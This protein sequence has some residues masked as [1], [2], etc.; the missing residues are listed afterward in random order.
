M[1]KILILFAVALFVLACKTEPKDYV[2][3][4]GKITNVNEFKKITIQN[5]EGYSKEITVNDDG[6]FKDT[7]KVVEGPYNFNDGNESGIIYL[8]NDNVTSFTLDTKSFDETLKFKGDDADKN[9]FAVANAL[10]QEKFIT[11]D[12]FSKSESEFDQTFEDLKNAYSELKNENKTIDAGFFEPIEKSFEGMYKSYKTYHNNKI[13]LLKEFPKGKPSPSFENY[14]NHKGGTTSLA[15]L[16]GKYVYVDVW[17]TWCGPCKRE[18][19]SLKK[20]EEQYHGKDIEFVSIS[21]DDERRSG[22]AEKA[23]E[24]WRTM[25]TEKELG[26][27][28]LFSDKA[29]QSDFIQSYKIT[30][31]PRF[32]LIDP[33]GNIVSAD[34]PRPSNPKLIELFNELNI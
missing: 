32:I 11:E 28:Q 8:K 15:D 21:V 29:W 17:A 14:E 20:V 27:T 26:G 5:R 3:L 19:P 10:L 13:A 18:I 7:L 34:A 31:I 16:R 9:N 12:I 6:T 1:K 4:S 25:V 33:N 2:T 30:G 24:A 22:S 23:N